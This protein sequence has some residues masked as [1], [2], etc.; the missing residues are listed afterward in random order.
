[1]T[2]HE[3][4]K[5]REAENQNEDV[6]EKKKKR[7]TVKQCLVLAGAWVNLYM[8]IAVPSSLTVIYVEFI[9]HFDSSKAM[10][11]LVVSLCGGMRGCAGIL[12]GLIVNR[13]GAKWTTL[14]GSILTSS[15]IFLSFFAPNM[16]MVILTLGALT[17]IGYS[18]I[19]VSTFVALGDNFG[20]QIGNLSILITMARPLAGM[21]MPFIVKFLIDIYG[22]RGTLLI[23]SAFNLHICAFS[24]VM[25]PEKNSRSKELANSETET[26][27]EGEGDDEKDEPTDGAKSK[28]K[29]SRKSFH[30]SIFKEKM[31][32][33][34]ILSLTLL[35][36][37]FSA[38]TTIMVD[39]GV[40]RGFGLNRSVLVLTIRA[41][42]ALLSRFMSATIWH[43][44]CVSNISMV[45]LTGICQGFGM[46]LLPLS[47]TYLL[48]VIG[49][50]IIGFSAGT[51]NCMTPGIIMDFIGIERYASALGMSTT[52]TGGAE[53]LSGPIA[54][55][56]TDI[57]GSY[58]LSLMLDCFVSIISGSVILL[59]PSVLFWKKKCRKGEES[60]VSAEI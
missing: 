11:G 31:Y 26:E 37:C 3:E 12:A 51:R 36:S 29:K 7:F 57:Y 24:I 15:G 22:W 28:K 60:T 42:S 48:F 20:D 19:N 23:V 5:L 21:T 17:G 53:V 8:C 14:L 46:L 41:F 4:E 54:G 59:V 55:K 18:F 27:E 56:I 25:G 58:D 38:V 50:V 35:N 9:Y 2:S 16:L 45:C 52:M 32:L 44:K 34:L 49:N 33:L 10:A 13:I 40:K 30:F 43:T 1:M 39:V 47:R 6:S